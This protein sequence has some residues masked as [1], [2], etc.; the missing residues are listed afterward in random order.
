MRRAV[1]SVVA[2]LMLATLTSLAGCAKQREPLAPRARAAKPPAG[3]RSTPLVRAE[4]SDPRASAADGL[5]TLDTLAQEGS[6]LA[7]GMSE[8]GRADLRGDK[9]AVQEVLAADRTDACVRVTFATTVPA[10]AMLVD[11]AGHVVAEV[12]SATIGALGPQ[13][14]VCIRKGDRL[15]LRLAAD[16]PLSARYVAWTAR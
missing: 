1:P 9:E 15:E 16:G 8:I 13:G 2:P 7:P 4:R 5:P 3:G 14:P 6:A 10:K 12:A 11:R